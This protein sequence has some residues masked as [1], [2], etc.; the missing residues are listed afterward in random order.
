[1]ELCLYTS[2]K[3]ETFNMLTFYRR[4]PKHV[5]SQLLPYLSANDARVRVSVHTSWENERT[6]YDGHFCITVLS[7]RNIQ[8]RS[9]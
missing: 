3:S 7:G 5:S 2:L 4:E 9:H 1:M 6:V 8:G